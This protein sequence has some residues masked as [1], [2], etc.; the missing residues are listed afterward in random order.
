[1]DDNEQ[2]V[3]RPATLDDLKKLIVSFNEA[4]IEYLL[5]LCL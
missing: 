2:Q 5:I 4:G 3:A 1:M